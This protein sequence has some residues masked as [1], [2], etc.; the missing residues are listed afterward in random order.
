MACESSGISEPMPVAA[1]RPAARRRRTAY[2]ADAAASSGVRALLAAESR[3]VAA[4][5]IRRRPKLSG[6]D[7]PRATGWVICCS[8]G[9]R[10]YAS[11]MIGA[12]CADFAGSTTTATGP[13][14]PPGVRRHDACT[15]SQRPFGEG[16]TAALAE[17]VEHAPDAVTEPEH[18]A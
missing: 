18:R 12:I 8:R 4:L 11:T 16:L 7:N 2:R 15:A 13:G 9:V 14:W 3:I 5:T 1:T 6:F 10:Q 17:H